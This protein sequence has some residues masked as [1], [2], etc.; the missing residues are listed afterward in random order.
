MKIDF[1]GFS[2]DIFGKVTTGYPNI[3]NKLLD[4]MYLY[5][6]VFG[7]SIINKIPTLGLND[8]SQYRVFLYNAQTFEEFYTE[9]F[10]VFD[11]QAEDIRGIFEELQKHFSSNP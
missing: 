3:L 11:K 10:E 1:S 6:Q 9:Y 5:L 4:D 2:S 7:S 8:I